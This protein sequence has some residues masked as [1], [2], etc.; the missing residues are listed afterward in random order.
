MRA[1]QLYSIYRVDHALGFYRTYFRSTDGKQSGFTPPDERGQMALGE[2]IMRIMSRWGEVVAEDL[3]AVPPFLRPSL[4]KIGVPGYRVLRWEQE[5]DRFRDPASWPAHSV[6]TNATHDTETTAEWYDALTPEE[7]D[8]LKRVPGLGDLDVAA[9]VQPEDG[10]SHPARALPLAV[11]AG[12]DPVSRCARQP[13]AD[14]HA[15]HSRGRQLA[16]PRGEDRGRVAGRSRDHRAA[17]RAGQGDR[18]RTHQAVVSRPVVDGRPSVAWLRSLA[19]FLASWMSPL[20]S[21]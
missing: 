9:P 21:A 14:Q 17:R 19:S 3:G 10:R 4:D 18:T 11:D 6:A 7:R 5:E 20:S 8:K 1:G 16:L 13:R 2:R 12:A 15:G